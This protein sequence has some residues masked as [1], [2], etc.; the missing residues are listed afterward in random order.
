MSAIAV[1]EHAPPV[2]GVDFVAGPSVLW[3]FKVTCPVCQM[4][5]PKIEVVDR[6]FPG[7][8]TGIG[9]DAAG[10]IAAFGAEHGTG[11]RALPD[12]DPYPVSNAF[13][14]EVVPTLVVVD[15]GGA[16]ADVV[17][18]WSRDGYNRAAVTIAE[19]TGSGPVVVSQASDGLPPFR[20]G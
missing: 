3:F 17:E 14:I 6:A 4:S 12:V 20:P 9:Q 5:A 13:G 11:I 2:A 16:V 19:L 8:V 15:S 1:G 10:D 7:L 18:S